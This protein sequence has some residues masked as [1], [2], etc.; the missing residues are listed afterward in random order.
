MFR[1][2]HLRQAR[3]ERKTAESDSIL[4]RVEAQWPEVRDLARWARKTREENHLTQLFK[5]SLNGGQA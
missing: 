4:Q 5:E 2:R 3:T 1:H